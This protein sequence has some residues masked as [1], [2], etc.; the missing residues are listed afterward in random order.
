MNI[1]DRLRL[2]R[3]QAGISQE[4]LSER[5]GVNRSYLSLVENGKSSPTFDFLEKVSDGLS[6]PVEDLVLGQD[7]TDYLRELPG[8]GYV[9]EG[10]AAFMSDREQMLLMNPS[11]EEI[12]ILRRIRVSPDYKPSK[13]FFVQ[14]LLDLRET[15]AHPNSDDS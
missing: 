7:I 14:A 15:R 6:M 3:R 4:T 12:A 9:Y 5:I 1:G 2:A 8:E 10:L 11:E 13:R